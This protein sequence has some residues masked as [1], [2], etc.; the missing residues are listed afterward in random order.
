MR[1]RTQE[2]QTE[3]E[4]YLHKCITAV[5]DSIPADQKGGPTQLSDNPLQAKVAKAQ[6]QLGGLGNWNSLY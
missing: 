5:K 4:H 1:S 3:A 6:K 2:A